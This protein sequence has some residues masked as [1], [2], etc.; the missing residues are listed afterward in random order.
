[1]PNFR[2]L[3]F[4]TL[5]VASATIL[6]LHVYPRNLRFFDPDHRH[7]GKSKEAHQWAIHAVY[8]ARMSEH[9][10][11]DRLTVST[12]NELPRDK[13]RLHKALQTLAHVAQKTNR[14]IRINQSLLPGYD[15]EYL[16]PYSLI[17]APVLHDYGVSVVEM[18]YW[19]RAA[20]AQ[21]IKG[22]IVA[23]R[24]HL[25]QDPIGGLT[26]AVHD[27]E[28][29]HELVF[30]VDELESIPD[31]DLLPLVGDTLGFDFRNQKWKESLSCG[32]DEI[33]DKPP[34]PIRNDPL[35]P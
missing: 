14:A 12:S 20:Q 24:V 27:D 22:E 1:M 6:I 35:S 4:I 30:D 28:S 10:Y 32:H 2:R 29:I 34:I 31:E 21:K 15:S 5:S 33:I 23:K 7:C 13:V 3:F 8:G 16:Q 26:Q 17:N 9:G 19:H 11:Y 25:N 18:G